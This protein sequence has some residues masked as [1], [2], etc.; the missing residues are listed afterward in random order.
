MS[1]LH[2][3]CATAADAPALHAIYAPI[4]EH[5]AISFELTVPSVEEFAGRIDAA[6]R[7]HAWLLAERDG[8]PVGYAYGTAHRSRAAYRF[9]TETSVY[10][11]EDVRGQGVGSSLYRSLFD[12]LAR[13][14]YFH[15]YA[16]ITVPNPASEA[17]HRRA[18]FAHIG[19]FPR[20]GFKFGRWHDVSWWHRV[21]RE[22]VPG[23]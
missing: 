5:T 11:H 9:S 14:G 22:G 4:V 21:L 17:A 19:T 7:S 6:N 1:D 3:R 20:V 16:G 12:E 15:A 2:I 8:R 18:G 13:L 10:V 23:D